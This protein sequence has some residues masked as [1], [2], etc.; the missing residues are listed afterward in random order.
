MPIAASLLEVLGER[1]GLVAVDLD[2][3]EV[4]LVDPVA[5]LVLLAAV[6]GEPELEHGRAGRHVTELGVAGQ[7]SHEGRRD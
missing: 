1:L 2:V 4:R 5:G 3:E 7:A 6:D